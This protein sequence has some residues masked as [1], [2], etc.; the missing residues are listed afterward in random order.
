MC[1][2]ASIL[3][4]LANLHIVQRPCDVS[5]NTLCHIQIWD[6]PCQGALQLP[7]HPLTLTDHDRVGNLSLMTYLASF[8]NNKAIIASHH[9]F[10]LNHVPVRDWEK[11]P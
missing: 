7:V 9:Y 5:N 11:N 8:P 4:L 10:I 1:V 3:P 6:G 2:L